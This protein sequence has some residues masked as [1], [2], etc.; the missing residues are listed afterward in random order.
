MTKSQA[1]GKFVYHSIATAAAKRLNVVIS[2]EIGV[3]SDSECQTIGRSGMGR[4]RDR[5][6]AAAHHRILTPIARTRP[7]RRQQRQSHPAANPPI[8]YLSWVAPRRPRHPAAPE[9]G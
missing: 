7:R 4:V 2:A 6:S 1:V 5:A 3:M 9:R 8:A